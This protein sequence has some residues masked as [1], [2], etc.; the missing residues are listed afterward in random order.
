MNIFIIKYLLDQP[1]ILEFYREDYAR[2]NEHGE[3]K[4]FQSLVDQI[5][6]ESS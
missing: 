2:M 5:L 6:D 3:I 4:P 1:D